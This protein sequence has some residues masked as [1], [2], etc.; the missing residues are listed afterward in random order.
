V[1]QLEARGNFSASDI[2]SNDRRDYFDNSNLITASATLSCLFG[3][4]NK[5]LIMKQKVI[6]TIVNIY[7]FTELEPEIQVLIT[8]AKDKPKTPMLLILNS[9]LELLFYLKMEPY[10]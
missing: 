10:F 7:R 5:I 9:T 8:K 3:L 1:L 2:Y 6:E 4:I